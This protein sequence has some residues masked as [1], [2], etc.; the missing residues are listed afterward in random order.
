VSPPFSPDDL[1]TFFTRYEK[2]I[3][4]IKINSAPPWEISEDAVLKQLKGLSSRKGAGP[5][6]LIPKVLKICCY[7]IAP[8]FTKLFTF[9]IKS[10]TTPN[11]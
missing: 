11:L 9:S 6:G 7:Q 8:V 10:K 1:N 4:D 3:F 5:D 2:P